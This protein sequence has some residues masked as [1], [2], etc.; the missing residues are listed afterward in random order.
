MRVLILRNLGA[1]EPPFRE[2]QVCDVEEAMGQALIA[3]GLAEPQ[4]EPQTKPV[5]AGMSVVVPANTSGDEPA[6][7]VAASITSAANPPVRKSK[8]EG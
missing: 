7:R 5:F 8:K 3:R 1:G 4:A 2:G 6:S